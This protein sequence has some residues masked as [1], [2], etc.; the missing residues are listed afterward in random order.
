MN[1][2]V[3]RIDSPIW[4]SLQTGTK[5]FSAESQLPSGRQIDK[6]ANWMARKGQTRSSGTENGWN[7]P[8]RLAVSTPSPVLLPAGEL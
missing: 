1:L 8:R 3:I 4:I 7:L 6:A 2:P 5:P